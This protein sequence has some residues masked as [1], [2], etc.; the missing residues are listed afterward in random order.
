AVLDQHGV[1][2]VRAAATSAARDAANAEEFFSRAEAVLG[3]RPELLSGEEEGRLSY[4][5]ATDGLLPEDGP[6]LVVDL[7]GGSTELVA[8]DPDGGV[9]VTSLDVGCVRVTERFLRS[10]P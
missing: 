7:G 2:A 10:D 3:V 9:A 6:Y 1:V 4:A 8:P 5:G